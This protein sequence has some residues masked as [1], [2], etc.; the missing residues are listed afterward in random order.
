MAVKGFSKAA[1]GNG[2]S[3]AG[4]G[5][6]FGGGQREG[7][8]L[9]GN[10]TFAQ[11][12]IDRQRQDN[13]AKQQQQKLAELR[14]LKEEVQQENQR[15]QKELDAA[16]LAGTPMDGVEEGPEPLTE[17]ERN[18]QIER[19]RSSLPYFEARYGKD[20]AEAQAVRDELE[21]LL[22]AAREAKPYKTHRAQL[23]KKKDKLEK[24]QETD[25]KRVED[26]KGK[27][28]DLQS[29][30]AE[31]EAAIVER[32]KALEAVDGELK[33]LLLKAIDP[34]QGGGGGGGSG[35]DP[36]RAWQTVTNTMA[37]MASMP[38]VPAEWG[39]ALQGLL[40]Q[41]HAATAA[42]GAAAA[43]GKGTGESTF[44]PSAPPSAAAQYST[45][46][47]EQCRQEQQPAGDGAASLREHHC[48][49]W[50]A[51]RQLEEQR[52]LNEQLRAQHLQRQGG[53]G[54]G[55]VLPR[56]QSQ[57]GLD[58]GKLAA[59]GASAT[60]QER[61]VAVAARE[62]AAAAAVKAVAAAAAGTNNVGRDNGMDGLG[63]E[64]SRGSGG[65]GGGGNGNRS[66]SRSRSSHK[67]NNETATTHDVEGTTAAASGDPQPNLAV[68][69]DVASDYTG[70]LE[71]SDEEKEDW[72][73]ET[74]VDKVP[75]EQRASVRAILTARRDRSGHRLQRHRKPV[76]DGLVASR[77]TR[78]HQK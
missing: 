8:N 46:V 57:P 76:Q 51:H 53:E 63:G 49:M 5:K 47:H 34:A 40:A 64:R 43:V 41:I 17:K 4:T 77:S 12:Q 61:A 7:N 48:Q 22:K 24:Q 62:A 42:M 16:R 21:V 72:E 20:S 31:A 50:Q 52:Q 73:M 58:L 74:I 32:A 3:A 1:K 68:E 14:K 26:I 11:R 71:S 23:E 65:D 66:R 25:A 36:H 39:M 59:D 55:S 30:L 13:R 70:G 35:D 2:K 33:E 15:L 19:T 29:Q 67:G 75:A 18:E 37:A 38:G 44:T 27:I 9:V 10:P 78:K 28:D 6:G 56:H 60:D 69:D 54:E 45:H